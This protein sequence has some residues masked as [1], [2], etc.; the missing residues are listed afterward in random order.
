MPAMTALS[1]LPLDAHILHATKTPTRRPPKD[2]YTNN[3]YK[4]PIVRSALGNRPPDGGR[5]SPGVS[6]DL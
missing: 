6:F 3:E 5:H 1:S 4:A 2:Q